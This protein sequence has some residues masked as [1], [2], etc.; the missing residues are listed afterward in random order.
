MKLIETVVTDSTV[1]MRYADNADPAKAK[2]WIDFQVPLAELRQVSETPLGD[3][4]SHY[5][6]T[7]R[8]TALRYVRGKADGEIQR[9]LNLRAQ[10][11]G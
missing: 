8:L 2:H 4:E 10:M 6:S 11:C 7:V 3:P 5:L 1:R 9:L